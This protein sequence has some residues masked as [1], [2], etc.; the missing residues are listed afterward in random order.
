MMKMEYLST[1]SLDGETL[2]SLHFP[3][4]LILLFQREAMFVCGQLRNREERRQSLGLLGMSVGLY[5]LAMDT[6]E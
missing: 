6:Q 4:A 2:L 3:T 5:H 1:V